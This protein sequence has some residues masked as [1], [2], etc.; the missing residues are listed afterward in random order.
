MPIYK[1][2]NGVNK[3]TRQQLEELLKSRNVEE[4]KFF[5]DNNTNF[6]LPYLLTLLNV[7]ITLFETFPFILFISTQ[8]FLFDFFRNDELDLLKN[9]DQQK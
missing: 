4:I 2:I 9:Q 1:R 5:K 7:P 6:F 3:V 8:L